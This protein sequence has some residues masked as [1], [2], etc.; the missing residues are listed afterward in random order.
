MHRLASLDQA[1]RKP[2]GIFKNA[3]FLYI[4]T[5]TVEPGVTC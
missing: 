3:H 4:S 1:L 5:D 2:K